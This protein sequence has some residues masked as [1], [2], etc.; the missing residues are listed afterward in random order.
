MDDLE[1]LLEAQSF[2]LQIIH[3]NK[4]LAELPQPARIA[5]ARAKRQ[6]LQ[7][8]ADQIATLHKEASKR[9]TRIADEDASLEKKQ[10]GVQVAIDAAQGDYR[11]VE[12]RTKELAGIAKRRETLQAEHAEA[13]AEA[14]KIEGLHQQVTAALEDVN[15]LEAQAIDEFQQQGGALKKSEADLIAKRDACLADVD[16]DLVSEYRKTAERLGSIAIG[17]LDDDRCGICRSVID[18]GR[19]IDLR[20]QAP[21]GRCPSCQRLL[22]IKL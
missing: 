17:T 15:R 7:K 6:A 18:G 1:R 12:A 3:L 10:H 19:L 22:I 20:N 16:A 13:E 21:L 4:Q 2:D 8:K 5:D 11:N 14:T 9:L